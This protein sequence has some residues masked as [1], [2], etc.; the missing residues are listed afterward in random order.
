[1][2]RAKQGDTVKVHYSGKLD[3]GTMFDSS[4]GQDPLQFTL[5]S[6]QVIPGFEQ[7]VLKMAVGE[8]KNI[9]IPVEQGYGEYLEDL[10]YEIDRQQV[11]SNLD[12]HVGQRLQMNPKEGQSIIVTV[13]NLSEQKVT[14]DA[15][16]PLAG[17][18]LFFEIEL[19]EIV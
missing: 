12:L 18:K 16:H 17:K 6:G 14:L 4:E 13:T 7:A 5:G 8:S 11:P 1:M 15:N 2:Q 19:V 3:D 10:I 9:E